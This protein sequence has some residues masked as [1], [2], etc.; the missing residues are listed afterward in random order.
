M[1]AI[2]RKRLGNHLT[3]NS[4]RP[5]FNRHLEIQHNDPVTWAFM[6][7]TKQQLQS[8]ELEFQELCAA[9]YDRS[10]DKI[11][12]HFD[13]TVEDIPNEYHETFKQ[14]CM[15]RASNQMTE[16]MAQRITEQ[17]QQWEQQKKKQQK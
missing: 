16:L 3:A 5:K 1:S 2:F 12:R 10:T 4:L 14:R 7:P 17:K 13:G 11:A 15:V 8:Q 9:K 6:N